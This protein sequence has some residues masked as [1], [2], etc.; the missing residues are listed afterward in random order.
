MLRHIMNQTLRCLLAGLLLVAGNAVAQVS[1]QPADQTEDTDQQQAAQQPA[2]GQ[3][4]TAPSAQDNN[5]GQQQQDAGDDQNPQGRFIPTEQ[6]SQD[7]GVSF[8]VD[9]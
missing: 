1:G 4:A 2:D 5:D 6:I 3:A 7:L 8:P 9:I